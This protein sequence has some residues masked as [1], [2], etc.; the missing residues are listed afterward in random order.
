MNFARAGKHAAAPSRL[1][2]ALLPSPPPSSFPALQTP[3]GNVPAQ[4]PHSLL[5]AT[6]ASR[7]P[8]RTRRPD[9][10]A[11]HRAQAQRRRLLSHR[12]HR[13]RPIHAA[14]RPQEVIPQQFI[15]QE[16]LSHPAGGRGRR[17]R[18][19]HW[20]PRPNGRP[21]AEPSPQGG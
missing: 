12:G 14:H 16:L 18:S 9:G 6:A 10:G 2:S 8:P 1:S 7:S 11:A 4:P 15:P 19:A 17:P 3:L 13:R 5:P 20:S 21:R